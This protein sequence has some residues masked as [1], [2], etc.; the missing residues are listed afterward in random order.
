MD[1]RQ[2]KPPREYNDD[3]KKL[4]KLLTFKRNKLELKG[5]ASLTSQQY[6]SDYDLFCVIQR[7]NSDEFF[8]FIEHVIHEIDSSEDYWFIEL[9]LQTTSGKK[10][11]MYPH[12]ELNRKEW[13]KVWDKL[14]FIKMDL[15]ARIEGFFIDVSVL[16]SLTQDS[17]SKTDYLESL[18]ADIKEL[19]KQKE[20]YKILKRRFNYYKAEKDKKEVLRLSR[21]FNGELGQEYQ[22][23]SRLEAINHLLEHYQDPAVLRKVVVALKDLHLPDEIDNVESWI[24]ERSLELNRK[25][26]KYL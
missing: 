18:D 25:A 2:R 4:I 15:V 21:I 6:F 9:K 1:V 16:Y 3:V 7:P 14:E 10:V 23:I 12:Q 13:D 17:P 24:K 11:R 5:S 20:W 26:K 19:S 8:H 22:L